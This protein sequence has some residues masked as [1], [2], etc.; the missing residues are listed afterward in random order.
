MRFPLYNKQFDG[1][2]DS[3]DKIEDRSSSES[4]SRIRSSSE[5]SSDS[6]GWQ[7]EED[8]EDIGFGRR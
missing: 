3:D 4:S 2:S 5:S 7:E 8:L 1:S 6:E